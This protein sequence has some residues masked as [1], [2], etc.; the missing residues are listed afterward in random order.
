MATTGA[1]LYR[2]RHPERTVLYQR[3]RA[4]LAQRLARIPHVLRLESVERPQDDLD[5]AGDVEPSPMLDLFRQELRF[6]DLDG[7]IGIGSQ[8]Q[9]T[10]IEG[11]GVTDCRRRVVL[12][13][14][15]GS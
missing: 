15:C 4:H 13:R 6:K 3:V 5:R 12:L 8:D 9:T 7:N 11:G 10:R 1:G 14:G 2:P